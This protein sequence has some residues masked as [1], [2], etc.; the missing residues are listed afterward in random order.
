MKDIDEGMELENNISINNKIMETNIQN[1]NRIIIDSLLKESIE[2][3]RIFS[4][5]VALKIYKQFKKKRVNYVAKYRG[6]FEISPNLLIEI[7]FYYH[8]WCQNR[9]I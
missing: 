8:L 1:R 4:A 9:Y 7:F 5:H 2:N 3:I 6:Q